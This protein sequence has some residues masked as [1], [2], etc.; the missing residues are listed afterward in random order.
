MRHFI[1]PGGTVAAAALH[2]ARA[3]CRR[4][5]R[6]IVRLAA[7]EPLG[8]AVVPYVNRLSDL[9]FVLGRAANQ[10]ARQEE[11]IWEPPAPRAPAAGGD[12]SDG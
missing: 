5:E 8:P 9:L 7:S 3:V 2:L 11:T 1:L 6:R 10:H 4:A 12:A